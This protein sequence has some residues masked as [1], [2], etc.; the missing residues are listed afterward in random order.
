[1]DGGGVGHSG[2]GD[3]GGG[4]GGP[5]VSWQTSLPDRRQLCWS[6]SVTHSLG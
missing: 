5:A 6:E 2:G 1:M 4:P 3:G